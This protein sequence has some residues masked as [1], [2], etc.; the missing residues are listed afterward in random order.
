MPVCRPSAPPSPVGTI[1]K[2]LLQIGA[3]PLFIATGS[4]FTHDFIELAG[5]CNVAAGAVSGRYSEE[6]VMAAR[7]DLIIVAMMGS[8]EGIALRE[9]RRWKELFAAA[10]RDAPPVLLIDADLI[11]SPTPETFIEGLSLLVGLI[12]PELAGRDLLSPRR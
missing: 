6:M 8:Q 4:S 12:H 10:G 7:P 5:G 2:V 11:C 1:P 9:Q 3:Q